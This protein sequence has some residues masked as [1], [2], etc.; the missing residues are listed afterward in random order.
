MELVNSF[1]NFLVAHRDLVTSDRALRLRIDHPSMMMEDVLLPQRMAG[2]ETLCGGFEYRVLCVAL[3]ACL[4]LKEFIALPVA[5]DIVNDRGQLHSICGIVTEAWAGDSDGGLASYQ[6][7]IRDALAMLEKRINTR[8]FRNQNEV[9]IVYGLLAEWRHRHA[10]LGAV[11]DVEMDNVFSAQAYPQREFTMQHNES[12]AAFIRRLLKRRGIA[13]FFRPPGQNTEPYPVHR[14]CLVNHYES[15]IPN[16]AGTVRYHRDAP[17]EE[18]DVITSW[19]AVRTLRPSRVAR[20]SWNY[21]NPLDLEQMRMEQVSQLA[22]ALGATLD[23]Y[24]VLPPHVGNDYED[25][26]SIGSLAMKRHDFETKCFMG[27]GTVRDFRVGE[28]FALTG[29][30]EIDRHPAEE[31]EFIVTELHL[32]VQNNLPRDLADRV[33]TLFTRSGWPGVIKDQ[34]PVSMRF[35]AVRRDI[36]LV[37]AYDARVDLPPAHMQSAIVVGPEAEEVH[38]D[39]MGRVRIRF[40][41]TRPDD[42]ELAGASNSEADSAWVRVTSS[43]AGNGPGSSQCGTVTLPRVGSEV[44]VAF[45]GGDPDKPVIVGQMYNQHATPPALSSGGALPDNRHLSGMR[46]REVGGGGRGNQLRF[47]DTNGEISVQVG[48]DHSAAQ[49]NLGLLTGSRADGSAQLRGDG[50]ELRADSAVA[51]RGPG[52]VLLSATA[53][54]KGDQLGRDELIGTASI[55]N[56]VAEQLASLAQ[57]HAGDDALHGELT[58]LCDRVRDWDSTKSPTAVIAA[59]APEG[60]LFTSDSNIVVGAQTGIDL[61]SAKNVHAAAGGNVLLRAIR[62]IS[63]FAQKVGMKLI[64]AG[65]NVVIQSHNGDIELTAIGSVKINAGKSIELQ[66]PAIRIASKGAQVNYGGGKVIQQCKDAYMIKSA[67]F[68]HTKGGDGNV[69]DIKFPSTKI[70]TDERVVLFN[71]QSGAPVAGR[72][73]RLELSDGTSVDGVTD[74]EGRTELVSGD[75]I[76]DISIIVYPDDTN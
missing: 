6:L 20:H 17:T 31:R 3:D 11:F 44:L 1:V 54:P 45:L 12:D 13:W 40:P 2:H 9:E 43:W 62:G 55:L 36:E 53:D 74:D 73:Y 64:A 42:H 49:L 23:D 50:A 18:R 35:T 16:A 30:A 21:K 22:P 60:M 4:P 7:V 14:M 57:T 69:A 61:V 52:G 10:S 65:G 66:A 24:Q 19:N 47:D 75:E 8:V 56:A 59:S 33:A 72:R 58:Q 70:E 63:I 15:V 28:Y 41:A 51:V 48:S 32:A 29:H 25:L 37:P 5:I 46:S 67:S 38:C 68:E 71:S 26:V 39:A 34:R 27:E 76:G